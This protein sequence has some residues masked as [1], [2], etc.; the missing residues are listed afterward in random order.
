MGSET[1]H[2]HACEI[3]EVFKLEPVCHGFTPASCTKLR[4]DGMREM[5]SPGA[6]EQGAISVAV[7]IGRGS[8]GGSYGSLGRSVC[9]SPLCPTHLH[10]ELAIGQVSRH[11]A[12]RVWGAQDLSRLVLTHCLAVP[13]VA[14]GL[15]PTHLLSG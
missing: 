4:R 2:R 5:P 15:R 12:G 14:G 1:P 6:R 8:F 11:T 3:S 13:Q 10:G 7:W 9:L